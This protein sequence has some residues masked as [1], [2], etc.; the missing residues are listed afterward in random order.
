[1]TDVL[2]RIALEIEKKQ[3]PELRLLLFRAGFAAAEVLGVRSRGM[4][5]VDGNDLRTGLRALGAQNDASAVQNA[6]NHRRT[7]WSEQPSAD[8][9]KTNSHI[10]FFSYFFTTGKHHCK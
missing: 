10:T 3:M 8:R 6:A 4:W 9:I 5:C 1:M 7:E 2:C